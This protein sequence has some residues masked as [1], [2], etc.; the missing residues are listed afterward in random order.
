MDIPANVLAAVKAAPTLDLFPVTDTELFS[1]QVLKTR[2]L[3][4]DSGAVLRLTRLDAPFLIIS[5]R[6]ILLRGEVPHGTITR[7]MSAI[8][9]GGTG[10]CIRCER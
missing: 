3:Q 1:G 5:A 10:R 6:Q 7:D 4:F 8:S 2:V 9:K